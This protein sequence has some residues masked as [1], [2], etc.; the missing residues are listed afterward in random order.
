M[1]RSARRVFAALALGL[2]FAPPARAQAP[3]P[4]PPAVPL[5]VPVTATRLVGEIKL[6]GV[7]EDAEWAG[8]GRVDTFFETVFG[9]NRP[10]HVTTVAYVAYDAK[11]L[12]VGLRCDDPDPAKIRAPYTDR[13]QI[14]GTDDNVAVFIDTQG[15]KRVAQEFRVS[16]RGIQ[17]DAVFNDSSGNEDFSPDFYYDTAAK[18]TDQGWTAEMRIPFSS[19]RYK[20]VPEHQW[21]IMIWRNYPR[22][23]RY[24]IYS[25]PIPR[26]SNCYVCNSGDL[27]GL[28]DLPTSRHLV[29]APYASG[30]DVKRASRPGG[31]LTGEGAESSF[32]LDFKWTP[33]ASTAI[34]LT[35]NPDFSQVETDTAQIAVNNRF[36]LFFPEKRPFFLEG[37]DLLDTSIP[38][39]Y[40]RSI[41]S[42]RFGARV[43]GNTSGIS[44][45]ALLARDEGGGS[46]ILPGALGSDFAPQDFE[47]NVGV[48]RARR[49]MGQSFIGAMATLK[50]NEG[51]SFNRVLSVDFQ[52]RPNEKDRVFGQALISRTKTPVYPTFAPEWDGQKLNDRGFL[53]GWGR[54]AARYDFSTR[55]KDLGSRLR[56]DLGFVPQV[57][58][59]QFD[60]ETGYKMYPSGVLSFARVYASGEYV[61]DHEG[62]VISREATPL[63][64][65]VF[66]K[67][68]LQAFAGFSVGSYRTGPELLTRKRVNY[69]AQV[70]PSRR[71][72]RI[73]LQGYLGEDI[74]LATARVGDG[75]EVTAIATLRPEPH[76]TIEAIASTSWLDAKEGD[77]RLFSAKIG[78][79]KATYNAS[80]R[81]FLR[82]IAQHTSSRRSSR[83]SEFKD[84]G[85]SGSALFSYRINWQT[86]LFIGYGDERALGDEDRL[87][88][89]GRQFFAKLSYSFQR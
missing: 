64:V 47:S 32:G 48:L 6:D 19:L 57:G 63:G 76:L 44:Y 16:P 58:Y 20:P 81:A 62:E 67:K 22:D 12:Y 60:I 36:A 13:D 78:R 14:F 29:V 49:E 8:A 30:Q 87:E 21:G 70:D 84:A 39:F 18:I 34:D 77:G 46:V 85:F 55:F 51:G 42:P 86:A 24:A 45:T 66:G 2:V 33:F 68:N 75:G 54:S 10:P 79:V 52:W 59:Q 61:V 69:L 17:G 73:A 7:L 40:S 83:A 37:V 28:S 53:L 56:A 11:Y 25:S 5:L 74:D 15:D 88:R 1:L 3:S 89:T 80:A 23:R 31:P 72:T 9:D 41:T 43:T 71:F 35:I 27:R 50:E 4:D 38:V 65:L 26:G 82:L